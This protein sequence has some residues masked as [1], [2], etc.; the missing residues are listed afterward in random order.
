[1]GLEKAEGFLIDAISIAIDEG[2]VRQTAVSSYNL[3]LVYSQ[4]R[5]RDEMLECLEMAQATAAESLSGAIAGLN[6]SADER[7]QLG[8]VAAAAKQLLLDAG[9]GEGA[10]A[11]EA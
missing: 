9:G 10:E 8:G 2:L 7:A 4:M 11:M 6:L 1:M 5:R 3:A